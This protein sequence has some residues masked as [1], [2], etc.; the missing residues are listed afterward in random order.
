M[1]YMND[2]FLSEFLKS[3]DWQKIQYLF[4]EISSASILWVVSSSGKV[5]QN[6]EDIY[7]NLCKLIRKNPDG[8]K[9]CNRSHNARFQEAKKTG[10]MIV[11]SCFCG[12]VG[13]AFPIIID[14]EIIAVSGGCHKKSVSHINSEKCLDISE[15]FS[16]ELNLVKLYAKGISIMSKIEKQHFLDTLSIFTGMLSLLMKW[17]SRLMIELSFE[18]NYSAKISALSEVGMLAAEE[19]NWE[20]MLATIVSKTRYLLSADSCSIYILDH[21]NNELVLSAKD[22]LLTYAYGQRIRLGKGIIGHV[23]QNHSA[24]I[25]ND[26]ANNPQWRTYSLNDELIKENPYFQSMIFAPL[27]AQER[28]IG[29]IGV[30]N[31]EPKEWQKTDLDF[32]RIISV[33]VS[34]IIEKSKIHKEISKELEVAKYMQEKLLPDEFPDIVGY[35]LSAITIPHNEVG[36]DYYDF[37]TINEDS[38]GIVI[39]DVCGKGIGA[40]ILMANTRGLVHANALQHVSVKDTVF[41]INNALYKSTS[42][43]KFVTLF[44]GIL[45]TKTGMFTY[46]NAGHNH[47]YVYKSLTENVEALSA[48]GTV[49]GMMP[50]LVYTESMIQIKSGDI[51]VFYSDGITEAQN[52]EGD[53]FGEGRLHEVV[54]KYMKENEDVRSAQNLLNEIY[55]AVFDFS[56]GINIYDDITIIVLLSK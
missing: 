40:A 47:P 48:G 20:E 33:N 25:I 38:L 31:I 42:D 11:S 29:V 39:A 12:L 15:K 32:L 34:G 14:D 27:I 10:C 5:M 46:T 6:S 26:I 9:R 43:D 2:E 49:L 41:N 19:L 13:F 56:S 55:N 23:A 28:L 1:N 7:P 51:I 44:Y 37:L 4:S 8:M 50:G 17:M 36:G 30:C 21:R 18:H 24:V 22:G 16:L 45:N 3:T 52:K 53:F 54:Y 35:D